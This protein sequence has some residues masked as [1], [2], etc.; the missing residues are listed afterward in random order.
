MT[1]LGKYL[2]LMQSST[3]AGH[4]TI[5]AIDHRGNLMDSLSKHAPVTPESFTAFKQQVMTHL[6]PFASA[7]LVDPEYGLRPGIK[8]GIIHGQ[9]GLLAPLEVTNYQVHASERDTEFIPNWSV[10][11][12]KRI[13]GTGV[14]LLLYYNPDDE[15]KAAVKRELVARIAHECQHY[16]IPFFL[17]P[18]AYGINTPL[19]SEE[20]RR[21]VV[22]CART[23][24]PDVLKLEF[25]VAPTDDES[26]WVEAL[27][28]VNAACS[29]PW[30]LLSAGADYPTFRRQTELACKAGAS[31][32]IVGRAIWAEA[33]ALQGEAR[34]HFLKYE[35]AARIQELGEICAAYGADWRQKVQITD[36]PG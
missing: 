13:G 12:I 26:V 27:E 22:E 15:K 25:P 17:E 31:G 36:E 5:L 18:I 33:V 21:L 20:K 34:E 23:F 2:H 30:T 9:V 35:A 1:T 24:R 8:N 29:V 14:K 19:R 3:P 32:V 11:H 4:F 28:E 10:G 6:V 16:D 7:V